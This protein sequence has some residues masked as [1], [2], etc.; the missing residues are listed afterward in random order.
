M[1][2]SECNYCWQDENDKFPRCHYEGDLAPCE[3][4]DEE[5]YE[6]ESEEDY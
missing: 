2:C 3:E 1:K 5:D 4:L 6:E